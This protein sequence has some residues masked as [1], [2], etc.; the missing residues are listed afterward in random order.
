M[1]CWVAC[2]TIVFTLC[3]AGQVKEVKA[4]GAQRP[5][6]RLTATLSN[7]VLTVQFTNVGTVPITVDRK[8]VLLLYIRPE[9]ASNMPIACEYVE[10]LPRPDTN[11]MQSRFLSLGPGEG[12]S[13][14]L[15]I[16]EPYQCFTW[17][18]GSP[19]PRATGYESLQKLPQGSVDHYNITYYANAYGVS[20]GLEFYLGK[21][22][23][24]PSIWLWAPLRC[25][26][27]AERK[28]GLQEGV[29]SPGR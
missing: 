6:A 22:N 24:P 15:N 1:A 18:V 21:S 10:T 11:A 12:T 2:V 5:E 26:V 19:G 16:K 9:D 17:G 8:L 14:S 27:P 28:A 25:V 29:K 13:R 7:D 23:V 20:D 4:D 3:A